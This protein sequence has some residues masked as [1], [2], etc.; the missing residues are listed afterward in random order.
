MSTITKKFTSVVLS[1]TTAVWLSG[2]TMLVP[3]AANAQSV[4]D[5]QA[6][7]QS[8][9][10]QIAQ[11]QAQLSGLSG[12]AAP[13]VSCNFA[14][15]L[16]L[17][18]VGDD[19][20]CLQRYLNGAGHQVAASGA[21]SPG[22]ETTYFGS[23]SQAAVAKWQAA[24]GVAPAVGYFGP[25]SRAKYASLVASAPSVPTTPTTPGVP[26]GP[27]GSGLTVRLAADQPAQGLFGESFASRPFTK[28]LFTAS[29]DGDV[30]VKSLTVQRTGQGND[31]AFNGVI[32]L[33]EDGIRIGDAKTFG[34]DHTLRL[35]SEFVVR[36]GQTKT[37][38]L[39]G[40]SDAD[41]N[42]YNGQLVSLTLTAVDAG[43]TNVNAFFPMTGP[44]M[45]VNST[46]AIGSMTVER[47][48]LDPGNG[49][50]KEIGT[51][52]YTF[53]SLRLTA[54]SN[55]DV[56]L[57]SI[58][59][60]QSSS[61]GKDDL[62]NIVVVVD[63]T[64]YPTTV[65]ADGKYFTAKFGNGITIAKGNNKE[66]SV[67]GDIVNGS[68]RGVDFDLYRYADIKVMGLTYGYD[69]LPSGT[70]SGGSATDDDGSLQ[71]ANPNFDAYEVTIGA[72]TISVEKATTVGATNVAENLAD[73]VLGGILIDVKGEPITVAAINLDVSLTESAGT[74]GSIDTNDITNI[75]LVREADGAVVA[76]P[77][78]GAAGG[79]NAVRF[80]DTVEFRVGREV[81][82]L[83]GKLGTDFA[84][85]DQIAASTTPSSDFTTVK[86]TTS[87]VTIT[88]SPASA[89]TMS[90]MTVKVAAMTVTISSDTNASS[91]GQTVV[92]GTGA[93][94]FSKIVL[95]AAESGE[96]LRVTSIRPS[97]S[98]LGTANSADDLTNCQ[99]FDGS[100]ALNSGTNILNPANTDAAGA[101]K[102]FT[103]DTG[104]IIPKGTTKILE[105]KCN[106]I[107]GGTLTTA[108]WGIED[109]AD[110]VV[111]TGITSGTSVTETVTAN[112][113]RTITATTAGTLS[114]ALDSSSPSLKLAQAGTVGHIMS[115]LRFNATNEDIQLNQIGLQLA[116]STANASS[117]PSDFVK[118][119][120]WDGA[121]KVGDVTFTSNFATATLTNLIIPKDSQKLLVVKADLAPINTTLS[122][123]VPGHL[124]AVDYDAGWGDAP[125]DDANEGAQG[126]KANG[127][128]SGNTIY[129]GGSDTSS[130][131]VRLV[132]AAPT[133]TKISTSGKFTNTSD[134]ILYRFKI[135]APAGTN[136]ISLYKFNFNLS[137]TTTSVT[138][139]SG[140]D[141]D[142]AQEFLVTNLRAFCY[143]DA[144]FS[145]GSCGSSNGQLNQFGLVVSNTSSTE[146]TSTADFDDGV[147][148]ADPDVDFAVLFNPTATS[149]VTAEAIVIP[150]GE[151]RYF[152]LKGNVTGASSSPSIATKLNGDAAWIAV[153]CGETIS[154][155]RN[156]NDY[157][158]YT[159]VPCE[160][161]DHT[162]SPAF[163]AV[164][165]DVDTGQHDRDFIW[166]DNAT[167]T[168]QSINTASWMNGFLI[169][170]L[171]TSATAS[172][173]VTL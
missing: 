63:G 97:I 44:D 125:D 129:T 66:A 10:A 64:S 163:T 77:V 30:T 65:S 37:I 27:V 43:N 93:Y 108:S 29:A 168:S 111:S 11:L 28:L 149:G 123:A 114:L 96:D 82:L 117:S 88:P 72:G 151:T 79:N 14:R 9:L 119:T 128:S 53:S 31:A 113:G 100:T 84:Q 120:L 61:A 15:T 91:P 76:G 121:T 18:V 34:S 3:V 68:N 118:V 153:G 48:A 101:D 94:P 81:Y 41:Q 148:T 42:D 1:A 112:N 78:D 161:S 103:L 71:N 165:A 130:N 164:A 23:L 90:T 150:A 124:V 32:A 16:T 47:G 131:G 50:T 62:A 137:T 20:K 73:Q 132:K 25:I 52:G 166:S 74:G 95:D 169:P 106:L 58:S 83:K 170:G 152:E 56:A 138:E 127:V 134:Q 54:G 160:G 13:S 135:E 89:V 67:K 38:T 8:L 85:N 51:N 173:V 2:F 36:A 4:S 70:N 98:V 122:Q 157:S 167:N 109:H 144:S 158:D 69:I 136:G 46:L 110:T 104:L 19:V 141:T 87:N 102:T 147:T 86:G 57:K 99:I 22:N 116:S 105:V 75:T 6:Q 60:N 145:L 35:T 55:E 40:D 33:D 171:P 5:L 24:N 107:A 115:V 49:V 45:T 146:T 12:G 143:S 39:A 17:G 172:E 162:G 156:T 155:S 140:G 7:I 26:S 80:T 21:G 92:A 142:P 139:Y 59:W 154:A 159:V 126:G 133:I